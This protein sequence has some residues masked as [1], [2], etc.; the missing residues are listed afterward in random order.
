[1]EK[2]KYEPESILNVIWIDKDI[3]N[4]PEYTLNYNEL[5]NFIK[6]NCNCN[7][8]KAFYFE[9]FSKIP[10][11]IVYI[12]FIKFNAVILIISGNLYY[13][14]ITEFIKNLNDI[15][16]IPKIIIYKGLQT[17]EK[18]G[19]TN[20]LKNGFYNFGGY[21][22]SFEEIKKFIFNQIKSSINSNTNNVIIGSNEDYRNEGYI[23]EYVDC[24]EKLVLP[25]FYKAL[26]ESDPVNS[27]D[28]F[29]S[30]LYNN[31]YNNSQLKNLVKSIK[32]IKD[33]PLELL[34][35]YYARIYTYESDFYKKMNEDLRDNN[36]NNNNNFYLPYIKTL[37]K[38]VELESL[39]LASKHNVLYRGSLIKTNEINYIKKCKEK[40]IKDLPACIVFAKVFLSFSKNE[41]IAKSFIRP[42]HDTDKVKVL[43][44]L[45]KNHNIDFSLSTHADLEQISAINKEKEVLFF[46]FSTFEIRDIQDYIINNKK[47]YKIELFYLGKYIKEFKKDENFV[48]KKDVIPESKFKSNLCQS[49]LVEPKKLNNINNEQIFKKFDGYTKTIKAEKENKINKILKENKV[50]KVNISENSENYNDLTTKN[51]INEGDNNHQNPPKK[52]GE[53]KCSKKKIFLIIFISSIVLI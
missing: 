38:G 18:L 23:F 21:H 36:N 22:D 30:N 24:K 10:E 14:F 50:D 39:N 29:I 15:Y 33:I 48:S 6:N 34:S 45:E 51:I 5:F 19:L 26:I 13:S 2:P 27:N 4:N 12:K 37:Y 3:H 42:D 20:L 41:N 11:A 1:M 43:F 46:P 8:Y 9:R 44:V 35:K 28:I 17:L 25:L 49:K 53:S 52:V 31:N 40:K 32:S 7:E 47:G 16:A